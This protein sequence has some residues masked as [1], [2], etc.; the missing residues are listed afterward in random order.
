[1][2]KYPGYLFKIV[3][4]DDG[5]SDNTS[6]WVAKNFPEVEILKGDGSLFWSGGINMGANYAFYDNE[7]EY[8]L[9]WNNDIIVQAD[10]FDNLFRIILNE[11]PEGITGSKILTL[12][13]KNIVWSFGGF[14]NPKTGENG[15][16]G[17]FEPDNG[18]FKHKFAVD[19]CTGMGTLIHHQVVKKIGL[20]DQKLFPQYYGDTDFCLRAKYAGFPVLIDPALVL[21]NDTSNTGLRAQKGLMS[22]LNS[23]F[24]LRSNICIKSSVIFLRKHSTSKL[25]YVYLSI[26]YIKVFGGYF[27]WRLLSIA[28]KQRNLEKYYH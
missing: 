18:S 28:G 11:K 16:Y 13:D 10:Y 9:L 24:S 21:Y 27:K 22:L 7:F 25:S 12:H 8:I 3:I 6:E 2:S 14:F 23:L 20:W 4:I 19:W 17:Y 26:F 1:V 15:M 5:S